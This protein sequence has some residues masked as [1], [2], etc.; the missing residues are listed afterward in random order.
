[1]VLQ[2]LTSESWIGSWKGLECAHDWDKREF[3][4]TGP[5]VEFSGAT[6]KVRSPP[7]LLGEHTDEVLS[8]LFTVDEINKL[9]SRGAISWSRW[10]P[11]GQFETTVPHMFLYMKGYFYNKSMTL[12]IGRNSKVWASP[13]IFIAPCDEMINSSTK[14]DGGRSAECAKPIFDNEK[15]NGHNKYKIC[16]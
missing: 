14:T 9:R 2:K 7:P 11:C 10:D 6:N 5:A 8:H 1:M 13:A 3:S 15:V 4:P 16:P 12:Q